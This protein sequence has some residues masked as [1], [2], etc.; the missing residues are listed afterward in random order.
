LAR[1]IGC[2][3]FETSAKT[4]SNIMQAFKSMAKQCK[5]KLVSGEGNGV[6]YD[7]EVSIDLPCR[8]Q[9]NTC[10]GCAGGQRV[11]GKS[12]ESDY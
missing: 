3:F 6:V 9:K 4:G 7:G 12:Y 11:D 2:S 10:S 5:D 1:E 8:L